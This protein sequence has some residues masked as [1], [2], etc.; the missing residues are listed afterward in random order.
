MFRNL[1]E[2]EVRAPRRPGWIF[3][4]AGAHA[5]LI[6]LATVFTLR[7]HAPKVET[8]TLEEL[9]FKVPLQSVRAPLTDRQTSWLLKGWAGPHEIPVAIPALPDVSFGMNEHLGVIRPDALGPGLSDGA[10]SGPPPGDGIYTEGLVERTV[11][12]RPDNP[13]P[14]YP[15]RLRVALVE[16]SVLVQFVVDTAGRVELQSPVI[17]RATH[18]LFAESVRRWLTRTRYSPAKADGGPVRQLVRQKIDF[19]LRP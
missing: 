17:L 3:T 9:V 15:A 16:G 12:P 6:G 2:S 14:A 8:I 5:T 11:A 7:D 13:Y 4:S 18:P 1:F 19:T 10:T